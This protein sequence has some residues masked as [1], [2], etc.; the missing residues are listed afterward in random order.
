MSKMRAEK[1]A[2]YTGVYNVMWSRLSRDCH[3]TRLY[4]VRGPRERIAPG[5]RAQ[6]DFSPYHE[7]HNGAGH[8]VA[9]WVR[10]GSEPRQ[11][12]HR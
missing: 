2:F 12:C 3:Y 5:L 6:I 1:I 11:L 4:N 9:A 10:R 8:G 7:I